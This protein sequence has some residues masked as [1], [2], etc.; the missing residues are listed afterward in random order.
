M[1]A[2]KSRPNE[3]VKLSDGRTVWLSRSA[4]VV[5]SVFAQCDGELYVLIGK[6]GV[7]CPDEVGK[8]GLVCGYLDWD[9]TLLQGCKRE[10]YEEAGLDLE[11]TSSFKSFAYSV[12]PWCIDDNPRAPHQ[13]I[14]H[15]FW[16]RLG[17]V[18]LPTLKP[19]VDVQEVEEAKWMPIEEA[20]KTTMAFNHSVVIA[21][22]W[23]VME[24]L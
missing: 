14:T 23:G 2:F 20:L 9:E 17:C 13:N 5:A 18:T 6:R 7:G 15:H 16:F 19:R 11:D 10:V 1:S 3:E 22:A 12:Q 8:W 24:R 4:T 21:R